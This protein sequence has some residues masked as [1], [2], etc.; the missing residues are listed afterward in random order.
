ME[1]EGWESVSC[2]APWSLFY[3]SSLGPLSPNHGR[4]VASRSPIPRAPSNSWPI[5]LSALLFT[6]WC[7][8]GLPAA[9]PRAVLW[10]QPGIPAKTLPSTFPTGTVLPLETPQTG[11]CPT[12]CCCHLL[13]PL[14]GNPDSWLWGPPTCGGDPQVD[15]CCP[16]HLRTV[17][18]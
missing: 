11:G 16:G 17:L 2:E 6:L 18:V 7:G 13:L 15:N 10:L 12:S 3:T 1:V 4:R 14:T 5:L 8:V 9:P